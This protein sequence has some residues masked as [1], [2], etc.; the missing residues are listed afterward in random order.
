M[1]WLSGRFQTLVRM[2]EDLPHGRI[3][4]RS[5]KSTVFQSHDGEWEVQKYAQ[6]LNN[7]VYRIVIVCLLEQ[8]KL[9]NRNVH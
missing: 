4:S 7:L 3:L 2:R 8:V 5:L 1:L 6:H 9:E